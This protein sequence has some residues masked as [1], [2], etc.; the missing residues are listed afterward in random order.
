MAELTQRFGT[1][2][3]IYSQ[4]VRNFADRPV[5]GTKTG[6]H[7]HW[8][9]YREFGEM[10][11]QIRGG[12]ASLG[13]GR[14]DRV[15]IISNN[16][17]EWAV[18]AGATYMLGATVVPMY[19]TQLD[20]D[21]KYI[22]GDCSAK[23]LFV[24]DEEIADRVEVFGDSFPTLEHVVVI[25]AGSDYEGL[26]YAQLLER[27]SARPA[28]VADVGRDDLAD[29]IY[30]S[31]T[32]GN[33]KGVLLTH[34]NLADN[35]SAELAVVPVTG[36]DRTLSFL[37]WAHSFGQTLELHGILA[38]GASMGIAE[39]AA[40]IAE[41]LMEVRPTLLI[42]VP[43][44]F[45][46][47]YDGVNALMAEEGGLKKKLFD[48]ALANEYRRME[49]AEAGRTSPW[50][51]AK[52]A[53]FDRL[54]FSKIRERFGGRLA[55]AASGSAA[56]SPEVNKFVDAL[57]IV[58]LQG[59][60]LSETSPL[61]TVNPPEKRKVGS[62]GPAVPGVRIELDHVATADPNDGEIIIYGHCVMKGYHNL[63][64]ENE[65]VFTEDGGLRTGDIGH[66]D[67]DGYLYITGRVKEQYKLE[68]GKYVVPAPIEEH[69][70]LSPF[71]A[72]IMIYGVNRPH[73]VALIVPD[74]DTLE[75]WAEKEGIDTSDRKRLIGD[76]R[77]RDLF[78]LE[79]EA[80]S[81]GIKSYERVR[82]F[83][84]IEEDFTQENGILS[85]TL[86]VKRREVMKRYGSD[87]E[88]LYR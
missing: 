13:V 60:G 40:K 41:N 33:P 81:E 48:A 26:T 37:P 68:N 25:D 14:G 23:V 69:V 88:S 17:V 19:E 52:H 76:E 73:N 27:G 72:N 35:V 65:A 63:P 15:A 83:F 6:D 38:V 75:K 36:D 10:I 50:V 21:W 51:E 45:N 70:R 34:A 82:D 16:R 11:D 84:L 1:L 67:E 32:T 86:K 56:L 29:I 64:E 47:V 87:L 8:I 22:I 31:G 7:W 79:I 43:R 20:K 61:A 4:A 28:P 66:L 12:L 74:F 39:S 49:M 18:I 85:Q 24:A 30:T 77:V 5:F 78:G 44:I 57:G 2:V 62:V 53:L 55:F 46:R 42:A 54:V 58:V 59:Y 3:D 80:H 71:I 9:T